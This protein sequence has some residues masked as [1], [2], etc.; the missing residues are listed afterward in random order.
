[1]QVQKLL[2]KFLVLTI[3]LL[4][5]SAPALVMRPNGPEPII[6]QIKESFRTSDELDN[7]LNEL[8]S[9]RN[10][11]HLSVVK[12]W[13][14]SKLLVMLSF[15]ANFTER[16][17]T[18]VIA[19][20]QQLAAVE[21][22]VEVSAFNLHF[23]SG[24]FVREYG[25][26]DTIPDV[27]RRGFD[28]DRIGKAAYVPPDD[29]AL[30]QAPHVPN[31]LIV[32][33]KEENI[34]ESNKTGF[35]QKMADLHHRMGCRVVNE[36][37]YSPTKLHQVLE[38]DD[39][40][41]LAAKLKGYMDSGYVLYAQPDNIYK[42]ADAYPNDPAYWS[43]PGPQWTLPLISAPQAWGMFPNTTKGDRS[44]IIAVGDS[45]ANVNHPEFMNNLWGG[46]NYNFVYNSTNVDDDN[47]HGSN[48][49]SI[50]GAEGNNGSCMTG[51]AWNTSLMI[52]KVAD[53]QGYS[54]SSIVASALA[55]AW[56]NGATAI[57]L[58][59]GFKNYA[60]CHSEGG[61]AYDCVPGD[62]RDFEKAAISDARKHNMVIVAS[63]GND[64][65]GVPPWP[66]GTPKVDNDDD[67]NRVFPASVPIDNV[68]SVL[69]TGP[70]DYRADYSC[71]GASRVDLGAPGG[72]STSPVMGLRQ[73]FNG[74]S[75]DPSNYFF[76]YGTSQAAPHV[77]GALAL[78]KSLFPWENYSGIRD[79]VLMG[80]DRTGTL[81]G[82]CRTNGRLNVYKALQTR[83]ML[84]NLSTRAR[85]E[86]G[87]NVMIAGFIIGGSPDGGPAEIIIRGLGPTLA[88]YITSVPT[89]GNPRIEL[90][91]GYG[92]FLDANNNWREDGWA[93]YVEGYGY[94][95]QYDSE[96]ALYR[97]LNPGAYTVIL[98][99]EGTA[100]GVGVVEVNEL[101]SDTNEKSRLLNLSTRC[102]V[103][104]GD[105]VAIAGTIIGDQNN[106]GPKPD[107]RVLIF[108]K[109]PSLSAYGLQAISDPKL[110]VSETGESNV[111]WRGIGG[112]LVEEL[113][114]AQS[115]PSQDGDSALWPT[116][117]PGTHTVQLS[118]ASNGARAIGLIE[119]YEK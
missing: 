84:R 115:A 68:I 77:T 46:Q 25:P 57:N 119:F 49:A 39:P 71:Y 32:G 78:I 12:W 111:G 23:R 7:R 103:G 18:T 105:E 117:T 96:A 45:G 88:P 108:G 61:G 20:L 79:R 87:D 56:Q 1:M 35:D 22:V 104:T 107:R 4:P 54:T 15:P 21:K 60:V 74:N 91:D 13:A 31:R 16:Q 42:I 8:T 47:G 89:L 34:W 48:V 92:N 6:V 85:V 52:L 69:A 110:T 38:F 97:S 101:H 82:L 102:L 33:W 73:D 70:N 28:A 118:S 50:I 40:S 36:F 27:A 113:Q 37:R 112:P 100:Y 30:L 44:V 66:D 5:L 9:T 3:L 17:A 26:N 95:P 98:R 41:T 81:E 29:T 62:Y 58:S 76:D 86:G 14:G 24:D 59:L 11:N 19:K 63:A 10:Q 75:S 114:E 43:Y 90:Y 99:D 51:V 83:S 72:T 116:F 53:F 80:V 106:T 109:G 67:L 2:S 93:A 94:A 64:G 55:Y 65:V